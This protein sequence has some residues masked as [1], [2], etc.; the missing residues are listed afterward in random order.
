[1]SQKT[2]NI[3]SAAMVAI[4][5][6]LLSGRTKDRNIAY[7]ADYLTALG[8]ELKEVRIVGD[9]QERIVAAVNALRETH[10]YV[11][12]SGGIGPTH[13][14]I[15]ADAIGDAFGVPV[16]HDPQVFEALGA[17][18][19]ARGIEFT[20]ARQRM[21]RFPEGATAIDNPVSRAPGFKIGNVH[22]LAGVPS[23][24]QA[25]LEAVAPT[26]RTGMKTLSRHVDCPFPEGVIGELLT[27]IAHDN[28][29]VAI[30]S[31]PRFDGKSFTVQI[32]VRGRD[33]TPV[34]AAVEAVKSMVKN[35]RE[36]EN[37]SLSK[38][39]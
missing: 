22:V 34:T 7:L 8:I 10:D 29:E 24:F 39:V 31:Y 3:V 30:G 26:L 36:A 9:E 4:G 2:A 11:F 37:S 17:H 28:P 5:D 23:V 19:A 33:E 15:T 12:T 18:Y 35:L 13:D 25:M 14:D 16:D 32:V 21:A 6:E 38:R 27:D 20:P 1:M